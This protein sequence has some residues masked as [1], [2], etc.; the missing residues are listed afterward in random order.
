MI[1]DMVEIVK[2]YLPDGL[3]G[4]ARMKVVLEAFSWIG[5]PYHHK[6]R[7]KQ[8]GVDCGQI[9]AAVYEA[10]GVIPDPQVPEDYPPDWHLHRGEERYLATVEQYARKVE[11]PKPGDIALF[12][13]GRCMSHGGIVIKW[14]WIIHSHLG[15]GVVMDDAELNQELS[16]R[17]MGFWSPWGGA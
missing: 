3:E 12:R 4:E 7:I 8:V 14:P 6:G 17:F 10:A 2:A 11:V 9:L 15:I 13:F 5:T 16:S 1:A